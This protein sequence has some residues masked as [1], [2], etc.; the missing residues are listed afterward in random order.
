MSLSSFISKSRYN[1]Q[2]PPFKHEKCKNNRQHLTHFT[3]YIYF[4]LSFIPNAKSIVKSLFIIIN[5]DCLRN[6]VCIIRE[7]KKER[8]IQILCSFIVESSF[9]IFFFL[10]VFYGNKSTFQQISYNNPTGNINTF[11]LYRDV[12]LFYCSPGSVL[13]QLL[14]FLLARVQTIIS[15]HVIEQ[16]KIHHHFTVVS[17]PHSIF[18]AF[19]CHARAIYTFFNIQEKIYEPSLFQYFN[20]LCF[21]VYTRRHHI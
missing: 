2:T 11:T 18:A 6:C 5:Y 1:N 9:N 3:Q 13:Y 15:Y 14:F 12:S 20:T 19:S 21:S 16:K 17:I 4:S 10:C 7:R 8:P